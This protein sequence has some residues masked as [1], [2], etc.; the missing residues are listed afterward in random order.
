MEEW[1]RYAHVLAII[2]LAALGLSLMWMLWPVIAALL[3][4]VGIYLVVVAVLRVF[5]VRIELGNSPKTKETK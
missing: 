1:K 3:V 4:C 5:R 2:I